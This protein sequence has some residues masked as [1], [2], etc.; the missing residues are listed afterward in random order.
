VDAQLDSLEAVSALDFSG[1]S[2]RLQVWPKKAE[3]KLGGLIPAE[4]PL[5]HHGYTDMLF[6]VNVADAYYYALRPSD[7]SS[8]QLGHIAVKH[9]SDDSALCR[10]MYKIKEA[11]CRGDVPIKSEWRALDL[12]ASP[13]GW[14][15][16]LATAGVA[17][18]V[19][20]DPGLVE[21]ALEHKD[22]VRHIPALA[23]DA[24]HELDR[25]GPYNLIC[26]DMNMHPEAAA[27]VMLSAAHLVVPGGYLFLTI[28]FVKRGKKAEEEMTRQEM[29]VLQGE[30]EGMR[31][32]W[33][34]ANQGGEKTLIARKKAD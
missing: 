14:S 4:I 10:A 8:C 9:T 1:K 32:M 18:V 5:C 15:Q 34:F 25:E 3:T 12:G 27:R 22:V 11:C 6:V 29:E 31:L 33:L 28:K 13:G 24:L 19:A 23:Q 17:R 20:V 16:Y 30:F 2:L 26:S 21:I 7:A